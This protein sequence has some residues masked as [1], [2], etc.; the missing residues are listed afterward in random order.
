MM[1]TGLFV[2]SFDP[3]TIGHHSVVRRAL[4]LFDKIVIGVGVNPEKKYAF[5]S[6]QRVQAIREI[7]A[8][9]P[10]IE[11][12]AYADLAIDLAQRV[13]AGFLIKGVRNVR[14][15][16]YE[17]D[18]ADFNRTMGGVETLLLFTEPALQGISSTLVRE[19]KHFGKDTSA[20]V[21]K[22]ND[23]TTANSEAE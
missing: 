18:Q 8:D 12:V 3:Y 9:E 2:G 19:M 22:K 15:F 20:F 13:G 4:P 17:R 11:V 21:P 14:D 23:E 10:R 7:Y 1:K 6:E 16:E 5:T